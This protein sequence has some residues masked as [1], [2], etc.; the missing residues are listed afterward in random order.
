MRWDSERT[1]TAGTYES[2]DVETLR[3]LDRA[4]VFLGER[5]EDGGL[6]SVIATKDQDPG[7]TCLLLEDAKL[8]KKS[9][10]VLKSKSKLLIK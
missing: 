6:T 7:F 8:A 9:H 10:V 2:L 1:S 4:D 5:P 3:G